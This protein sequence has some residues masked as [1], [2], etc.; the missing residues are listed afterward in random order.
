MGDKVALLNISISQM[1]KLRL[2]NPLLIKAIQHTMKGVL[3]SASTMFLLYNSASFSFCILL[4]SVLIPFRSCSRCR[5]WRSYMILLSDKEEV[6]SFP[7]GD[8]MWKPS[9]TL[10]RS[11]LCLSEI[12]RLTVF[13]LLLTTIICSNKW[14]L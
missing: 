10:Q 3:E 14:K 13:I 7:G 6:K 12:S 2:K 11:L 1:R 4:E 8:P 9:S 5:S